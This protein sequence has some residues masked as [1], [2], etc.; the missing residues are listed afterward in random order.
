MPRRNRSDTH[1]HI[2]WSETDRFDWKAFVSHDEARESALSLVLPGESFSI[3]EFSSNC[4]VCG[5]KPVKRTK[6][7]KRFSAP[8]LRRGAR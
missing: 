6:A 3:D 2:H 1:F 5:L 4:R 8:R 7:G